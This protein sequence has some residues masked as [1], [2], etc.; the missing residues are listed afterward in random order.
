MPIL[1]T[2][3]PPAPHR[4]HLHVSQLSLQVEDTCEPLSSTSSTTSTLVTPCSR[5]SCRHS[6]TAHVT[7]STT[8]VT[9]S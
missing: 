6:T 8:H 5:R 7:S 4:T 3:Q 9:S 1:F 2:S